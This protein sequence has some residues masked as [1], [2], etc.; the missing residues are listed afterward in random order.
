LKNRL[1]GPAPSITAA[2]SS[3]TGTEIRSR[4][5]SRKGL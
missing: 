4:G 1:I 2:S 3:S 5:D